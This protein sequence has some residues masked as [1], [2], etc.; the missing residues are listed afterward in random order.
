M[1]PA[2]KAKSLIDRFEFIYTPKHGSWLNMAEIELNVLQK[3]CLNRRI[4]DMG[5]LKKEVAAWTSARNN[6]ECRINWHFITKDSRI[7]LK[8]LS[9]TIDG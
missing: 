6:K 9:P 3:Q 4:P 5:I 7:K 8:R 1:Y 2:E